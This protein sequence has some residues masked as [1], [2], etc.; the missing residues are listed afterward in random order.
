MKTHNL[1]RRSRVALYWTTDPDK[2][3]YGHGLDRLSAIYSRPD[4]RGTPRQIMCE[5]A[6]IRNAVGIGTYIRIEYEH[7]ARLI[8]AQDLEQACSTS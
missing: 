1:N 3:G 6:R 7:C 2:L 5:V 4:F 8:T